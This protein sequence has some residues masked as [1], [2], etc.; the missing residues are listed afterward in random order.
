[1]VKND[2]RFI[3]SV[4][5]LGRNGIMHPVEGREFFKGEGTDINFN[6]HIVAYAQ[7]PGANQGIFLARLALVLDPRKKA[8][9]ININI[10]RPIR[11]LPQSTLMAFGYGDNPQLMC[12]QDF[13]VLIAFYNDDGIDRFLKIVDN[14]LKHTSFRPGITANE[15]AGKAPPTC[16]CG[17][18]KSVNA[19]YLSVNE[20]PQKKQRALAWVQKY[21]C[22]RC[23]NIYY[24][25]STNF[26]RYLDYNPP[27]DVNVYQKM[28]EWMDI[29]NSF[30]DPFAIAHTQL[31]VGMYARQQAFGLEFLEKAHDF[32]AK[33][34]EFSD[35][36][37][38]N[39]MRTDYIILLEQLVQSSIHH[40][41][42]YQALNAARAR[43]IEDEKLSDEARAHGASQNRMNELMVNKGRGLTLLGEAYLASNQID[44]ARD[45][46][47][48]SIKCKLVG[49]ADPDGNSILASQQPLLN[50]YLLQANIEG[51]RE[52]YGA[53]YKPG[54]RY[55]QLTKGD[56]DPLK[57]WAERMLNIQT[58]KKAVPFDKIRPDE[59]ALW[60]VDAGASRTPPTP[61]G[62]SREQKPVAGSDPPA[63]SIFHSNEGA[64][65]AVKFCPYCRRPVD[66]PNVRFCAGCGA[67]LP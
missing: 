19:D 47:V 15:F 21:S 22:V 23:M 36:D 16:S 61:F 58:A 9:S 11:Q 13:G 53:L 30:G 39:E 37:F 6:T 31:L 54:C 10:Y 42:H 64:G 28:Q 60:E 29:A 40:G 24:A 43:R 55:L 33:C 14:G 1:M 51:V 34:H 8:T 20:N 56:K 27:I 50:V 66:Q 3:K 4:T 63:V 5:V 18:I 38:Y 65:A 35:Q 2:A 48:E 44:N 49:G 32:L 46:L 52:L 67:R 7:Y 62:S 45:T 12:I 26:R 57:E 25:L 17:T 41:K 59:G